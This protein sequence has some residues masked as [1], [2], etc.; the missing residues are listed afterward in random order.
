MLINKT[1]LT[2]E[3]F[4][5]VSIND[6]RGK[7]LPVSPGDDFDGAVGY[8]NGGLIVNR[9]RRQGYCGQVISINKHQQ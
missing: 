5:N 6:T 3:S 4:L 1:Q 8:F 7:K 9:I 2:I